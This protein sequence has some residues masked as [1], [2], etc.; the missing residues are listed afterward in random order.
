MKAK[1]PNILDLPMTNTDMMDSNKAMVPLS[2]NTND[3]WQSTQHPTPQKS[4]WMDEDLNSNGE[5]IKVKK[6]AREM[7]QMSDWDLPSLQ[8]NPNSKPEEIDTINIDR[9]KL[10]PDYP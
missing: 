7:D 4:D 10:D 8:Y 3:M 2:V 5:K 6:L 1:R 9:L